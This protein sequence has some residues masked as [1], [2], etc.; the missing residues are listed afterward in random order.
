MLVLLCVFF[1]LTDLLA[2]ASPAGRTNGSFE[3]SV[4][5]FNDFHARF[6]QINENGGSCKKESECVGG[7]SRLYTQIK[8]IREE[9]PKSILLNAGDTFQGT[10]WYSIGR[11]NLTQ[12]FMNKLNIDAEVLGNHDFDDG[13]AGV[14]PYIKSLNHPV[15]ASNI[16]DSL[17]PDIQRTYTKSTIIERDG[18]KIGVIGVITYFCA[19]ISHTE[20]LKFLPVS[21]SVNEEAERL[22]RE[23]GV[24]TNIVLSHAAYEVDQIIAQNASEKISLIVGGHSHSY[25]YTGDKPPGT[26]PVVG[27]YPTIVESKNKKKI[28]IVQ[29]SAFSRYLGN[30]TVFFD[31]NGEVSDYSGAPI[32]LDGSVPQD[33]EINKELLPWKKM[34]DELGDRVVGSSLVDLSNVDCDRKECTL[35]NFITDA[36]VYSFTKSP[37]PGAWTEVALSVINAGGLRTSIGIGNITY[38]DVT[39]SQP[40]LNTLDMGEIEGRY[41]KE[42]LE[43]SSEDLIQVSGMKVEMNFD[44]PLNDRVV[45]VKVRCQNCTIPRYEY[46]DLNKTYRIAVCSFL[47]KGGNGFTVLSD[48]LKNV[49]VGQLDIDA[50]MDYLAHRS[51]I[52]QEEEGRLVLS[53]EMKKRRIQTGSV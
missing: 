37:P 10:L 39:I 24:F 38:S 5:H 26:E 32:Y 30:I 50:V 15:V 42:L 34:V 11:W 12:H 13:I 45:S 49:R 53:G 35:G 17:E 21:P 16:D 27:P 48:N 9:N 44:R 6:D 1:W 22:V 33:E 36:T 23:E 43:F 7:F 41:L 4:I 31:E 29:A 14:V 25:L 40:F 20:K 18:K 28:L 51:P 46:L 52:Y 19:E 2:T 47:R 3:L 8:K